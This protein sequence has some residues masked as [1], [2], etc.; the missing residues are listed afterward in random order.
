MHQVLIRLLAIP[1]CLLIAVHNVSAMNM[2]PHIAAGVAH[3]VSLKSDGSLWVWGSNGS[4]QLG[5]G[6]HTDSLIPKQIGIGY[7]MIA[8]GYAH[9]LALMEN[10]SLWAWGNN[11][12]GQLDTET[13]RQ[14][15]CCDQCRLP[16]LHVTEV[17]R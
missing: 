16:S 2:T 7:T 3:T 6:T 11:Y 15:L 12:Y 8:A 1:V 5:D 9:T 17:R 13:N 4:G 14:R 10:G